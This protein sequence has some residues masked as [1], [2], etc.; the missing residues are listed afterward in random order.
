[1]QSEHKMYLH[2]VHRINSIIENKEKHYTVTM[3]YTKPTLLHRVLHKCAIKVASIEL[4]FCEY[5]LL[6]LST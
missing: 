1:M 3:C 4:K 2:S 6:R 5:V